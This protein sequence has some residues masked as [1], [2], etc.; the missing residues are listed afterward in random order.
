MNSNQ[1]C[2]ITNSKSCFN[3]GTYNYNN[4]LELEF[5]ANFYSGNIKD[6]TTT[7][8]TL[9]QNNKTDKANSLPQRETTCWPVPILHRS[10]L[11]KLTKFTLQFASSASEDK[12]GWNISIR[13]FNIMNTIENTQY[14]QADFLVMSLRQ[15]I[16]RRTET[17]SG[18]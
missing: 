3:P 16:K 8:E 4:S 2:K 14:D 12:E 5:Y 11:S 18:A 7:I 15:L 13:I 6:A 10:D 1:P 17:K 9:I